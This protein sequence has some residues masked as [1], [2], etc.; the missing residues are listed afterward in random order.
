V[1]PLALASTPMTPAASYSTWTLARRPGLADTARV[2][3]RLKAMLDGA[4]L[5]SFAK[6][7]GIRGIH[8]LVPLN[9]QAV[10]FEQTRSFAKTAALTFGA[11]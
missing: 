7:S 2:A 9:D 11:G 8:V 5:K 4:K 1:R 3:L 6:L 10:T